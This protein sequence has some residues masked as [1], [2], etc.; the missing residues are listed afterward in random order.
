MV[1]VTRAR[2]PGRRWAAPTAL[3][4]AVAG[5]LLTVASLAPAT[6]S[7]AWQDEVYL[8]GDVL[9]LSSATLD[10]VDAGAG[11]TCALVSGDMWC[12][13]EGS[14]GQ[15]GVGSNAD[16]GI[17]V[18]APPATTA[19]VEGTGVRV[20]AG[21]GYACGASGGRAFCWGD[22][23]G[24]LGN[25]NVAEPWV[26]NAVNTPT[27]VYDLPAGTGNQY[28]SPLAGQTV[29]EV[30]AGEYIACA[31]TTAGTAAC[32]GPT[33]GLTRP[34]SGPQS[35][36]NAPIPLP[37]S[38]QDPASAL[39]PGAMITS[40]STTFQNAC[41]IADGIAYCWGRNQEGQAGVG[42]SGAP[43]TAPAR[44]LQGV[45]PAAPVDAITAGTFHTCAVADARVFCWGL[46]ADGLIG[47]GGGFTGTQNTPA[48]VVGLDGRSIVAVS[49]GGA[50]T[51]ALDSTGQAWCW[52]SNGQGQLGTLSVPVGVASQ[53]PVAVDQ[54]PGVT[55]TSI[56]SGA[57]HTCAIGD[58]DNIYC[59]GAAGA[60]GTGDG[61]TVA[62]VPAVPVTASWS[63]P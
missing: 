62:P 19:M 60:L 37:T 3:A 39:P 10:Q 5:A 4:L 44:V 51:C 18:S 1:A 55:F 42:A 43:V 21:V 50:A 36:A 33:V 7:A 38:A 61:Q 2:R 52:G 53:V 47:D 14:A 26:A 54:P 15:L 27:A 58:D 35:W 28:E 24:R 9:V 11:F 20:T 32:W 63:S 8:S 45:M 22:G 31:T 17:P 48:A 6:T 25:F 56:S 23:G 34:A 30:V 59:W 41:F 40:L 16:S 57:N 13:G 49:A 29:V 12:W 46:R